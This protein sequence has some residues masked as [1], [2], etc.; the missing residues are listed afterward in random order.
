MPT[1]NTS[2]E[3]KVIPISAGAKAWIALLTVFVITVVAFMTKEIWQ[4]DRSRF[5]NPTPTPTATL[6]TTELPS[7]SPS[8]LVSPQPDQNIQTADPNVME[9]ISEE[10]GIR[11]SYSKTGSNGPVAVKRVNNKVYIYPTNM[12]YTNGQYVEVFSKNPTINLT[13]A[14]QQKFLV[15][16][17]NTNCFVKSSAVAVPSGYEAKIIATPPSNDLEDLE[18]KR[19]LCPPIYTA[20]NGIAY[21]EYSTIRNTTFAYVSVGQYSIA[22]DSPTNSWQDTLRFIPL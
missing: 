8:P 14:I 21:F 20:S 2:D 6:T 19:Q 9:F 18:A 13:E 1:V 17:M 15:G 4:K 5:D 7:I 16:Y 12:T 10:L 22:G 11:F 3:V